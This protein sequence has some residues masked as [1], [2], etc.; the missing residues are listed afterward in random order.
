MTQKQPFFS[1]IIPTLNEEFFLPLLLKDLKAQTFQDF[2]VIHVDG[3]SDDHTVQKAASFQ[4]SLS[5]RTLSLKKRNVGH[6]RNIGA[7]HATGK[8]FIFMDADNRLSPTF[9]HELTI[10]LAHRPRLDIFTCLADPSRYKAAQKHFVKMSNSLITFCYHFKYS[11]PVVFGALLGMRSQVFQAVKFHTDLKISED[12]IFVVEAR[13]KKFHFEVLRKPR[14]IWS[15]RR[16]DKDRHKFLLGLLKG[17]IA[18][19]TGRN[20]FKDISEYQMLGGT[21][22]ASPEEQLV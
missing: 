18:Y 22:Y 7:K 15:L 1:I 19:F 9:L 17:G 11:K 14:Y 6:Q 16:L 13:K 3:N 2:E 20:F 4:R 8:W 12:H 10:Q 5:L 21:H